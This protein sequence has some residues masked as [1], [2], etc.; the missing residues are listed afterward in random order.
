MNPVRGVVMMVAA[1]VAFWKGWEIHRGE[2][3]VLAYGLG[4][5]ALAL[6]VWHLTRG[7]REVPMARRRH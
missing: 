3:A 5:M 2:T 7:R 6:G 4:A 1:V